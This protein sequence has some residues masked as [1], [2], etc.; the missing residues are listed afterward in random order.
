M[1]FST[2][3]DA[4]EALAALGRKLENCGKEPVA[5]LICGGSALNISGLL[6]RA[7][8][9]VDVLG[10]TDA[11]GEL[12]KIPD[13]IVACAEEVAG[14][15]GLEASWLNDAAASVSAVGLP[16]GILFR[17]TR[18]SFGRLLEV[19]IAS[20]IDLIALKCFAALDPRVGRKHLGDLVDLN[21][22]REEMSF[23]G[24]WLLD[25]RTSPEFRDM[26]RRLCEVLGHS[27]LAK[28]P[29]R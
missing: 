5:L 3:E 13:W 9:D 17:A 29:G 4:L 12:H 26:V 1:S 27:D 20:R 15:L 19:A 22:T 28:S 25:R 21:P 2:G 8:A 18:R 6:T 10:G 16:P 23:A 7:T 14:E 24:D 11:R